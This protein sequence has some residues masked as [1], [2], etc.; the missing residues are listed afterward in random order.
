MSEAVDQREAERGAI[1][2]TSA[3]ASAN[4]FSGIFG[5]TSGA[6]RPKWRLAERRR[7]TKFN[8][9]AADM[10]RT[11]VPEP[12]NGQTDVRTA[13]DR[14]KRMSLR[15]NPASSEDTIPNHRSPVKEGVTH[16]IRREGFWMNHQ[17][18]LLM[19]QVRTTGVPFLRGD[20]FMLRTA[21]Q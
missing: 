1:P 18:F 5:Q 2:S 10:Q 3:V 14:R 19:R 6:I 16:E 4:D 11:Q 17:K 7:H 9:S 21:G 12:R 15:S 20:L 8:K 13:S